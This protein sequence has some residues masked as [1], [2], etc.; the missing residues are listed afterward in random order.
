M[1][2]WDPSIAALIAKLRADVAQLKLAERGTDNGW[3]DDGEVERLRQVVLKM[4]V[5]IVKADVASALTSHVWD[6]NAP[7]V[8][9]LGQMLPQDLDVAR[10]FT[11]SSDPRA[12][13]AFIKLL[14]VGRA[15]RASGDSSA[16]MPDM[17]PGNWHAIE[18]PNGMCACGPDEGCSERLRRHIWR[19]LDFWHA[20]ANFLERE[21]ERA[22]EE[23]PEAFA[24]SKG[25]LAEKVRQYREFVSPS[26]IVQ[27]KPE[28][29][30]NE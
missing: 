16:A 12:M 27:A 13:L 28:N 17:P 3:I 20:K 30:G 6:R 19:V 14:A 10:T 5:Q 7:T 22:I 9:Y 2:E 23:L 11:E 4:A 18:G 25:S 1:S 29:A 24:R 21:R 15:P 26:E 8:P